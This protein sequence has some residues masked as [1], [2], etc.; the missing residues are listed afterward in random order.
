MSTILSLRATWATVSLRAQAC[1]NMYIQNSFDQNLQ[2]DMKLFG[3]IFGLEPDWE[4]NK[5]K[6]IDQHYKKVDRIR[7]NFS[8]Y[9][10]PD[11]RKE[12]DSYVY[13]SDNINSNSMNDTW[14]FPEND[15]DKKLV[16]YRVP[17]M[18]ET[19]FP[20]EEFLGKKITINTHGQEQSYRLVNAGS[21]QFKKDW[22]SI[23]KFV[24]AALDKYTD[25][26]PLI[27]MNP[28]WVQGTEIG[29]H[30]QKWG[31]K[32]VTDKYAQRKSYFSPD[33]L[34]KMRK[35]DEDDM[36]SS[37]YLFLLKDNNLSPLQM[38][39]EQMKENLLVT[40]RIARFEH[41]DSTMP[42][43]IFGKRYYLRNLPIGTYF[44]NLNSGEIIK[45]TFEGL[46]LSVGKKIAEISRFVRFGD[47]PNE[48]MNHFVRQ[49]FEFANDPN[50]PI[51]IFIICVDSFGR[52]LFSQRYGFKDITQ[53]TNR[54]EFGSEPEYLMYIDTSSQDF[55]NLLTQL[56]LKSTQVVEKSEVQD[57]PP[58]MS[59]Y[60][61]R[62]KS[63][64]YDDGG[65][66]GKYNDIQAQLVYIRKLVLSEQKQKIDKHLPTPAFFPYLRNI[67]ISSLKR[68]RQIAKW[69]IYS[70]YNSLLPLS[71]MISDADFNKKTLYQNTDIF[72]YYGENILATINY[73][74]STN[75]KTLVI[76]DGH[77]IFVAA[78]KK[79]N[80]VS[81][82]EYFNW[83]QATFNK[84]SVGRE[85]FEN[86]VLIDFFN[87]FHSEIEQKKAL[88]SIVT[89]LRRGGD[90]SLISVGEIKYNEYKQYDD[91]KIPKSSKEDLLM[92]YA[93][94]LYQE[95]A[96]MT[97]YEF[98]LNLLMKRKMIEDM[99]D[100]KFPYFIKILKELGF[101]EHRY[102]GST[103]EFFHKIRITKP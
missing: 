42:N 96:P 84:L 57:I 22:P 13:T 66:V 61:K 46:E 24:F 67:K 62:Y 64:M 88:Q 14:F 91:P 12:G 77:E 9:F 97:E 81:S 73:N 41:L 39:E 27:S 55:T 33:E 10:G 70:K 16:R 95:K 93:L 23:E 87:H 60:K 68:L 7:G 83:D 82:I 20:Y 103:H 1:S 38:N 76:G 8:R 99:S 49:I 40:V 3:R 79:I 48:I 89:W 78:P 29:R 34:F 85:T 15:V 37:E 75:G 69:V 44:N 4:L 2:N 101:P 102:S 92:R 80:G 26:L 43:N 59:W 25:A 21:R 86:I 11:P 53:I 71:L 32:M 63:V 6:L 90:L 56:R 98:A 18:P 94:D 51:N 47:V 36:L 5:Y 19:N 100:I 35:N 65:I 52:Q 30:W 54:E 74:L 72:S 50:D 31:S 17:G 45:K 28:V 58:V